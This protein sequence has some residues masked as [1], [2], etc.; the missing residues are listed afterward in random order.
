MTHDL[1]ITYPI[2]N[3]TEWSLIDFDE[4]AFSNAGQYLTHWYPRIL[5][6]V[7]EC[8]ELLDS[9]SVFY[10]RAY[11]QN[12]ALHSKLLDPWNRPFKV[13]SCRSPKPSN[14]RRVNINNRAKSHNWH[15]FL[16][17][18]P[19]GVCPSRV[20]GEVFITSVCSEPVVCFNID[21]AAYLQVEHDIV[22]EEGKLSMNYGIR[23]PVV[24]YQ[25]FN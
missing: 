8:R 17:T 12:S 14:N 15:S 2:Q 10:V 23:S 21:R 4:P 5:C 20:V 6:P 9:E 25:T 19:K 7:G 18:I 1:A 13:Y 3:K 11:D 16:A 24:K 22:L